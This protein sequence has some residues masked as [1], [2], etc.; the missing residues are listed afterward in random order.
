MTAPRTSQATQVKQN[1]T[2][3][4]KTRRAEC[5]KATL[6]RASGCTVGTPRKV[7]WRFVA[8]RWLVRTWAHAEARR[9]PPLALR[10][11]APRCVREPLRRG[12]VSARALALHDADRRS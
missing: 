5:M 3:T 9:R 4:E 11:V 2:N 7:R 8:K 1:T 12:R 10:P 6:E